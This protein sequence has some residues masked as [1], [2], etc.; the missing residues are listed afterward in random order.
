MK[1]FWL[2]DS[3]SKD[4]QRNLVILFLRIF[5][6]GFL[7]RHGLVKIANFQELV[8]TFPDPLWIGSEASLYLSIFAEAICAVMVI[9]GVLTRI[10]SAIIVINMSVAGFIALHGMP[11]QAKELA[12][13]YFFIFIAI[14]VLGGGKYSIDWVIFTKKYDPD[15]AH[16]CNISPFQRALRL[17]VGFIFL[18][19]VLSNFTNNW[20]SF[21][22]FVAAALLFITG[23]WGYCP[24]S[25]ASDNKYSKGDKGKKECQADR[26]NKEIKEE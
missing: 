17:V 24:L 8:G 20:I 25:M 12:L 4:E 16:R 14:A 11:F 21:I 26:Q 13:V 1:Q 19:A 2:W 22:L 6:G 18:Y 5:A 9:W 23:F 15:V 3:P 7:L 10:A